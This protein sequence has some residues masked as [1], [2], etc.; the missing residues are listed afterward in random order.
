MLPNK[1]YL[2][3]LKQWLKSLQLFLCKYILH[4]ANTRDHANHGWLDT[5]YS[6]SFA[7]YYN[8]ERINFGVLRILNDNTIAGEGVFGIPS[9]KN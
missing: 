8:P 3:S 1:E 5:C 9:H 4:K 2:T 6:F 7:D